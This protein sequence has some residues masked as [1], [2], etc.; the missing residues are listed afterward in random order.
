MIMTNASRLAQPFARIG[1]SRTYGS[2]RHLNAQM[3]KDIGITADD[4][5]LTRKR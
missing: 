4:L 1:H 2:P 3:L 5:G